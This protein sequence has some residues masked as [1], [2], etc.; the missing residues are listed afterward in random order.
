LSRFVVSR[1]GAAPALFALVPGERIE[2]PTKGLQ[3]RRPQDYWA[4]VEANASLCVA[5]KCRNISL[6]ALIQAC[7]SHGDIK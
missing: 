5:I 6:A 2:L 3:K 4:L 7:R 1:N